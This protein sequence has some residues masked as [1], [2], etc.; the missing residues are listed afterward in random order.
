MSREIWELTKFLLFVIYFPLYLKSIS[1]VVALV[2]QE[3]R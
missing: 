3:Q 1:K 2:L